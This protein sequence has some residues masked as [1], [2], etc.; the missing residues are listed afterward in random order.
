MRASIPSLRPDL[1]DPPRG[2]GASVLF[3]RLGLF[4]CIFPSGFW[5]L[6]GW[7]DMIYECGNVCNPSMGAVR[8]LH[9]EF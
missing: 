4:C 3:G 7:Y 8:H 1:T 2:W 5:K 6:S 9:F